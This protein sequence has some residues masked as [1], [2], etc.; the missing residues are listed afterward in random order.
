MTAYRVAE[1][2]KNYV[3]PQG[4]PAAVWVITH[5]LG[6]RPSVTVVDSARTQVFGCVNYVNDNVCTVTFSA[7]FSG[8]AYCN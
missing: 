8:E 2:D 4:V 6:K 7:P 3:H 1:D 5:N